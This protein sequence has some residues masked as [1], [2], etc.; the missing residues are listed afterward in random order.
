MASFVAVQ[1]QTG[2]SFEQFGLAMRR[3]AESEGSHP[4]F[5]LEKGEMTEPDFVESLSDHLEP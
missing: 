5:A 1:D 2:I 3:A 4:L